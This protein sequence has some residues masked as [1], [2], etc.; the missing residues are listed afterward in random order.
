MQAIQQEWIVHLAHILSLCVY[1]AVGVGVVMGQ[2]RNLKH[3][4]L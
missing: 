4:L 2:F 3:Y 1:M